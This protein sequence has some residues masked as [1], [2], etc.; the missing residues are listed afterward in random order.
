MGGVMSHERTCPAIADPSAVP[1]TGWDPATSAVSQDVEL[2]P[3]ATADPAGLRT[4]IARLLDIVPGLSAAGLDAARLDG[5]VRSPAEAVVRR[6]TLAGRLDAG[7]DRVFA[8][9]SGV[10]AGRTHTTPRIA[11]LFPGHGASRDA[12]GALPRRFPARENAFRLSEGPAGVDRVSTEVAH[13]R[14]VAGSRAALRVLR[15]LG[16]AADVALGHSLGELTALGWA[17]AMDDARPMRLA[18]ARGRITATAGRGAGG[19]AA[20]AADVPTTDRLVNGSGAV[21]AGCHSPRQTV[22]SGP[23]DAVDQV[24]ERAA[25]EGG[26]A[27]RINVPHAFQS[28]LVR[29]AADGMAERVA[30]GAFAPINRSVVSTVAGEVLDPGTDQVLYPVRSGQATATAVAG[31]DLAVEVGPGRVLTGLVRQIAPDT[32]ALSVDTDDESLSALRSVV[33][34]AHPAGARVDPGPLF[35]DRLVPP[36]R[37]PTLLTDQDT[38]TTNSGAVVALLSGEEY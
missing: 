38:G 4:G 19:M 22:G 16:V 24:C 8:P 23:A 14:V 1:G 7:A 31:V 20:L 30:G 25:A 5:P 12:V 17:G 28:P 27:V 13:G 9:E 26:G 15:L 2:L 37:A 32:P 36:P 35:A 21:I 29:P 3:V 18:H 6:T 10:F 34:A 33:G 11:Y